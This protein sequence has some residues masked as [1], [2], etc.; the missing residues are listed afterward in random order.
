MGVRWRC[1]HAP[2][3]RTADAVGVNR[4]KVIAND[5]EPALLELIDVPE[6]ASAAVFFEPESKQIVAAPVDA[7]S[8]VA[9]GEQP[10]IAAV[11]L[12]LV[13]LKQGD[14]HL[15]RLSL[16]K[17]P[18]LRRLDEPVAGQ[19]PAKRPINPAAPQTEPV[20]RPPS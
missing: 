10:D 12:R 7:R 6:I 18:G 11:V 15:T 13:G 9:L 3:D 2:D 20:E 5:G 8:C 1:R 17:L 19:R 16:K 4:L 14:F